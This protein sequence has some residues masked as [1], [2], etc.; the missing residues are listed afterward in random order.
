MGGLVCAAR[1]ARVARRTVSRSRLCAAEHHIRHLTK[2]DNFLSMQCHRYGTRSGDLLVIQHVFVLEVS[3]SLFVY[4]QQSPRLIAAVSSDF[5][6]GEKGSPAEANFS[7]E[8]I[9]LFGSASSCHQARK[10]LS[11]C[12]QPSH[13]RLH[14]NTVYKSNHSTEQGERP[15]IEQQHD[16]PRLSRWKQLPLHTAWLPD[17]QIH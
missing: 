14:S 13:D 6:R 1:P 17:G 16:V 7:V 5:Q 9:E 10:A 15:R 2:R 4:S 12:H 3:D 8:A 11:R